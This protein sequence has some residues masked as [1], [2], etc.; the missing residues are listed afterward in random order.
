MTDSKKKF[1][2][3]D[4][5]CKWVNDVDGKS[6]A[7]VR[8]AYP[9]MMRKVLK[10]RFGMGKYAANMFIENACLGNWDRMHE[11]SMENHVTAEMCADELRNDVWYCSDRW[12]WDRVI[13]IQWLYR[14]L[15]DRCERSGYDR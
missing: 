14:R 2:L 12:S 8:D 4:Y 15:A 6:P 7:A 5:C 11:T 10:H 13:R 3:C 9:R 1:D